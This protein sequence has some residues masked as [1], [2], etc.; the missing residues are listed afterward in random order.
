[1]PAQV[2][3]YGFAYVTLRIQY[4]ILT[5]KLV[6]PLIVERVLVCGKEI[7]S[8]RGWSCHIILGNLVPN[9]ALF[10]ISAHT[11]V[12]GALG[13]PRVIVDND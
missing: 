7:I 3:P 10:F 8:R 9:D 12:V 1:V 11:D 13:S 4:V 6:S 5:L 2:L